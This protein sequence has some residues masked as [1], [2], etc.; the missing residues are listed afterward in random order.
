MNYHYT[1]TA[2]F[3]QAILT[4][5]ANGGVIISPAVGT[6]AYD[7]DSVVPITATNTTNWDFINWIGAVWDVNAASTNVTMDADKTVTANCNRT[8]SDLTIAVSGSGTVSPTG[9]NNYDVNTPVT[10]TANPASGYRFV[11]WTGDVGTIAN[12]NASTTT[13]TMSGDYSITANFVVD[14]SSGGDGGG[15]GG[16]GSSGSNGKTLTSLFGSIN[17]DGAVNADIEAISFNMQARLFIPK[18]TRARDKIG[19]PL[20][21][22]RM[23]DLFAPNPAQ[24]GTTIIGTVYEFGP[25]GATFDPPITLTI[26]YDDRNLPAGITEDMFCVANWDETTSTYVPIDFQIDKDANKTM[27]KVG[28]FSIYTIL[29]IPGAAEFVL[30]DLQVTPPTAYT[31]DN[32]EVTVTVANT[33]DASGDYTCTLMIDGAAFATQTVTL[34]AGAKTTVQ[35]SV[36]ADIEGMYDISIGSLSGSYSVN[37]T[38]ASFEISNLSITPDEA[39]P[40]QNVVISV[41]AANNGQSSGDYKVKLNINGTVVDTKEV[42]LDGGTSQT[43]TFAYKSDEP[44]EKAIE[45]N[46]LTGEFIVKEKVNPPP[47]N[48]TPTITSTSIP[49]K[50]TPSSS[51]WPWVVGIACGSVIA[52][53]A[54][55]YFTWWRKRTPK[56]EK[57]LSG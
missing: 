32:I 17:Q 11:N 51:G 8:H 19:N 42:S 55:L 56:T 46:G 34:E 6:H 40:D 5:A 10:I 47:E 22:I 39:D 26:Q 45:V 54:V 15:G 49:V 52:A 24:A 14:N 31:G 18:G 27:A 4:M 57:P 37:L 43:V 33:G 21:A 9:T 41:T 20:T 23:F 2:N 28:H 35:F 25:Q 50:K 12:V 36:P 44:G 48:H 13:I 53:A 1:I 30:S 16:G 38:P 29:A 7:F 3:A